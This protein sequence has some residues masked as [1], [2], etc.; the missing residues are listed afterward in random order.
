MKLLQFVGRTLVRLGQWL[1]PQLVEPDSDDDEQVPAQNPITDEAR[2][3]M[4][5][6]PSSRRVV[7]P[8]PE[9]P[10]EG[11]VAARYRALKR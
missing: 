8:E 11:S 2:S 6:G 9:A 4:V 5:T 10:L 3:M 1:D 7:T